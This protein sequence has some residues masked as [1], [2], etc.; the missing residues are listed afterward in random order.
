MAQKR[1]LPLYSKSSGTKRFKISI[2][3]KTSDSEKTSDPEKTSFLRLPAEIRIRI[4]G[5][6]FPDKQ[7]PAVRARGIDNI[8]VGKLLR[9]DGQKCHLAITST[10]RLI[11]EE[12]CDILYGAVPY[13]IKVRGNHI[14]ACL[15]EHRI[16][17][18]I[19]NHGTRK[20]KPQFRPPFHGPRPTLFRFVQSVEVVMIGGIPND[21]GNVHGLSRRNELPD[22]GFDD[23]FEVYDVRNSMTKV[24]NLLENAPKLKRVNICAEWPGSFNYNRR[25]R[26][27]KDNTVWLLKPLKEARNLPNVTFGKIAP[28]VGVWWSQQHETADERA[29]RNK[30]NEDQY[31]EFKAETVEMMMSDDARQDPALRPTFDTLPALTDLVRQFKCQPVFHEMCKAL[32]Q[33]RDAEADGAQKRY[34]QQKDK[35]LKLWEK[36][37]QR[38][39]A[40]FESVKGPM[41]TLK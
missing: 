28:P 36:E 40:L 12:S 4:Y 33:A 5:Y 17:T 21:W 35:I 22:S 19:N 9:E 6:L 23:I 41:A 30:A 8:S 3:E 20:K 14:S 34:D 7:V 18:S 29:K 11:H 25:N 13:I 26:L 31:D 32:Y 24:M 38:M 2:P 10:C 37:E 15:A 39:K 1:K 27:S 16:T